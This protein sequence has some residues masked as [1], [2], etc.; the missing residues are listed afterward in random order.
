MT[1]LRKAAEMALEALEK[2]TDGRIFTADL[3]G[4]YGA[5]KN[6]LRQALAQPEQEPVC[7]KDP[8]YCW[9][10]RCQVGKVCKHTA[11]PKQ[12]SISTN[13]HLCAM[14]RQVH[15]VLACTALPMKR[16]WVGLTKLDIHVLKMNYDKV[17][18]LHTDRAEDL[19]VLGQDV[20]V[21]GLIN[22]IE[23]KLKEK[24]GG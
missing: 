3:A 21:N 12:E 6:T 10:I 23:A 13:D 15:D 20:D 8:F 19:T 16:K 7:D 9:S 11:Q 18:V 4:Y 17:K 5:A 14:L 24:N 2:L 22:A 1:D